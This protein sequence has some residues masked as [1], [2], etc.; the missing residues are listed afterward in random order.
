MTATST[1]PQLTSALDYFR[2]SAGQWQ[3][4]RVTHHLAFRRAEVGESEIQ[5]EMLEVTDPRLA[6]IC[7]M[8]D[9]DPAA[10]AGGAL[11]TWKSLMAWD[12]SEEDN[13]EGQTVMV[14]VPDATNDRRGKLLRERGYAET[15]PVAGEYH[16]D[17]EGGMVLT[18]EYETMSS[19]ER[20]W[21]PNPDLRM[22]TSVLKRFGGFNTATFCTEVRVGCDQ[23]AVAAGGDREQ[24][25][26]ALGW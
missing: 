17:E 5:V 23:S 10:A 6:E 14:I 22:R 15:A 1:A 18:T 3:S 21:F 2:Q 9:I 12:A 16:L 26:S 4:Q 11:V 19:V 20:F 25:I 24:A 8:Y 13:H 7:Q